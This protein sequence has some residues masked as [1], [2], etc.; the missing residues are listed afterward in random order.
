MRTRFFGPLVVLLTGSSLT[1]GQVP[2][3]PPIPLEVMTPSGISPGPED[4]PWQRDPSVDG[5]RFWFGAEYLLWWSRNSPLP[6]PLVTT[7]A[8]PDLTPTAAFNQLGTS[9]LLGNQSIDT[10]TRH[11]A[12]FT[13]GAW[14]DNRHTI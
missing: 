14:L 11:G 6:V 9:V 8:N 3:P 5:E 1:L 12:R 10:G 13:A 2:E 4:L 7:T